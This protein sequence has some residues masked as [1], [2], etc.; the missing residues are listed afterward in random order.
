MQMSY[1]RK[2]DPLD[3]FNSLDRAQ[4]KKLAERPICDICDHPIQDDHY[5]EI[6]GDNICPDC[7]ENYFREEIEC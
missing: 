3:D 6:N 7:L 4:S 5:Y 2:G 1:F